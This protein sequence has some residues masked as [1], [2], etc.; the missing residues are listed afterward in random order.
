MYCCLIGSWGYCFAIYRDPRY[1]AMPI[2][3]VRKPGEPLETPDSANFGNWTAPRAGRPWHR[4]PK[5]Y[6]KHTV[7]GKKSPSNRGLSNGYV[8]PILRLKLVS[9]FCL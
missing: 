6:T 4:K 9:L 5:E 8:R 1:L 7:H 2:L 3:D